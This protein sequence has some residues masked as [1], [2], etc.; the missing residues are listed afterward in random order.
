M[1]DQNDTGTSGQLQRRLPPKGTEGRACSVQQMGQA[2][3]TVTMGLRLSPAERD[4][5]ERAP[6]MSGFLD[7]V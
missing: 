1:V 2:L 7:I 3:S 4:I 6:T 5:T